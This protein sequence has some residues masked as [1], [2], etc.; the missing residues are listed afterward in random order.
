MS[1]PLVSHETCV[2][3]DSAMKRWSR[4]RL[5]GLVV[6][7]GIAALPVQVATGSGRMNHQ[8]SEHAVSDVVIGPYL[9]Y[10]AMLRHFEKLG[11]PRPTSSFSVWGCT[12][13]WAKVGLAF[14]FDG[15]LIVAGKRTRATPAV[16]TTFGRASVTGSR[17]RTD[18]GLR[19]GTPVAKLRR[20][21]PKAFDEGLGKPPAGVRNWCAYWSLKPVTGGSA[22]FACTTHGRV[23]A[24]FID[25]VGR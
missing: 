20:F 5:G 14:E 6:A 2:R 23:A 4:L 18:T 16:C 3:E 15:P 9:S 12:L 8:V 10:N 21:Y 22:L 7:T 24:L 11:L 1:A 19:V 17:W 13:R 25:L